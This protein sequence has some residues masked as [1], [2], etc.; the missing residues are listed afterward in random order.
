MRLGH[1]L[2]GWK[3]AFSNFTIHKVL[4]QLLQT[5]SISAFHVQSTQSIVLKVPTQQRI[6]CASRGFDQ[7][8]RSRTT[9]PPVLCLLGLLDSVDFLN[10]HVRSLCYDFNRNTLLLE[11]LDHAVCGVGFAN[12]DSLGL[13]SSFAFLVFL[14]E[15]Q[16]VLVYIA[17]SVLSMSFAGCR[18]P[19]PDVIHGTNSQLFSIASTSST[20]IEAHSAIV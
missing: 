14:N 15:V 10:A 7:A 3:S 11:A 1:A 18:E 4:P 13:T 12:G 16:F 20:G 19:Q 8:G 6:S 9:S 17:Y 2:H 5:A